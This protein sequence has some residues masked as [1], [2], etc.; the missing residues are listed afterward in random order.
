V[1]IAFRVDASVQIGSGHVVRCLTLADALSERGAETIFICREHP[2]NLCELIESRGH[3]ISRL[4]SPEGKFRGRW[5]QHAPWLGVDR[6]QDAKETLAAISAAGEDFDWLVIDHYAI[7]V[8]WG[9][10]FRTVVDRIAVIDDLADRPHD[11]DL[12]LDQN[13]YHDMESRYEGLLPARCRQLLG[14][15]YALLRPEFARQRRCLRPRDGRVRRIL[16]FFGGSDLTNE[17]EKA[18]EAIRG[19]D[20][21]EVA[22]DVVVGSGNPHRE[23]I[24]SLCRSLP[25]ADFHCQVSNMAEL[26]ASADLFLGAGG[27]TSWERFSVGLPSLVVAVAYNQEALSRDLGDMGLVV[28]LGRSED[29]NSETVKKYLEKMLSCPDILMNLQNSAMEIVDGSGA[30]RVANEIFS[31]DSTRNCTTWKVGRKSRT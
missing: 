5:N 9:C 29:V 26:M 19:A 8:E 11:C 17:T 12:L 28:Y 16:I 10:R 27:S 4:P 14:P 3:R 6:Q 21:G 30:E 20:L 13:L 23:R 22:I 24:E 31:I 7:D 18:L 1:K 2:G 25:Q 15:K